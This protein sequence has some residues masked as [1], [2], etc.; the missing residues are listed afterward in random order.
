MITLQI[1]GR[2]FKLDRKITK[3]VNDKFGTLDRY[4]PRK[5]EG[6]AGHVILEIDKSNREDNECVCE[7]TIELPGHKLHA[8]E[9]TLNMYAAVD[10]CEAKLKSQLL[11]H[12]EKHMPTR[13]RRR[14]LFGKM[15]GRDRFTNPDIAE[16]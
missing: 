3:Y 16:E 5:S 11:K 1:T 10:I 14:L 15:F 6:A 4:I 2:N 9:A 8:H 12:K 7:V 13:N